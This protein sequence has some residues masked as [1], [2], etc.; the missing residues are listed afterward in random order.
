MA[1]LPALDIVTVPL[2]DYPYATLGAHLIGYLN[3]VN[4]KDLERAP[5]PGTYRPGD[6][7]GR[8]G[9]EK[10]YEALL[11]GSRGFRRVVVDA[12]GK[13]SKARDPTPS[14]SRCS[15]SRCPATTFN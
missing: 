8:S 12:R 13:R 14:K 1:E 4:E 6:R 11:K 9:L 10:R 7:I 15:R 3:E 5:D 2:R